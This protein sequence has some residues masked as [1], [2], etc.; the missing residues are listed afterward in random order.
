VAPI[1]GRFTHVILVQ[2]LF[3]VPAC[4]QSGGLFE[5][6]S[7]LGPPSR[8]AWLE[9]VERAKARYEDF[10]TRAR[11]AIHPRMIE[12]GAAPP[13]APFGSATSVLDDPTLR[14]DDVVVTPEGLMVFRGSPGLPH[15]PGD[16]VPVAAARTGHAPELIELQR[17]HELG[18]R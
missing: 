17:A 16:F 7:S 12:P 3:A 13:R 4:A 5:G 15:A 18:K 8:V 14:R 1:F 10:A 9:R 2:A 11:L 6:R